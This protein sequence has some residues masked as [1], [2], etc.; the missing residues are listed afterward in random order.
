[1]ENAAC[2]CTK[3][4]WSR[5]CANVPYSAVLVAPQAWSICRAVGGG[6]GGVNNQAVQEA[7]FPHVGHRP[8]VSFAA[9]TRPFHTGLQVN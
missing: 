7:S 3:W 5:A 6:G 4:P 9:N 2:P 8:P 1:M